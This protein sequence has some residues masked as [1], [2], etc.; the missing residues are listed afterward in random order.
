MK[1]KRLS[2]SLISATTL[3]LATGCFKRTP[4]VETATQNQTLLLGNFG[5]PASLDPQLTTGVTEH[6]I[7]RGLFEGLTI[8]DPKDLHPTPGAAESW[9]ISEDAKTYTFKLRKNGRWSNGDP[10]TA[11]DFVFS[12]ERILSPEFGAEYASMLHVIK[13]A[14][15]YNEGDLDDFTQVG[16][17]ALDE[18]TLEIT[19]E[20]PTPY[21][22]TMLAPQ[23]LVPCT[24]PL[25]F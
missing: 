24:P 16:V 18:H 2:L 5:D 7:L 6:N 8:P 19:L 22:I 4:P 3:L 20:H 12:Y 23:C 1:F 14:E 11:H 21:F 25:P 9:S 15:A 13:N 17:K 10:V